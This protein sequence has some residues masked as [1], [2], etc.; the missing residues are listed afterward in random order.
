MSLE[1]ETFQPGRGSSLVVRA[2]GGTRRYF[3]E[4]FAFAASCRV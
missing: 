3:A 4:P 2:R 1:S